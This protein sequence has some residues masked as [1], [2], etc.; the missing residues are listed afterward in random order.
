MPENPRAFPCPSKPIIEGVPEWNYQHGMELRDYFAAKAMTAV[1]SVPRE[2]R[3]TG[4]QSNVGIA[5]YAYR[6]ADVMLVARE[7]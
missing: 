7:K 3:G 5:A 6:M 1:L 2:S 4:E